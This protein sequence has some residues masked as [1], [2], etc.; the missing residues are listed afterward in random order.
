MKARGIATVVLLVL[1]MSLC[2]MATGRMDAGASFA[3]GVIIGG[4]GVAVMTAGAVVGKGL[5][6]EDDTNDVSD[7]RDIP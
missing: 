2:L 1:G 4:I 3:E 7:R 5:S 6:F